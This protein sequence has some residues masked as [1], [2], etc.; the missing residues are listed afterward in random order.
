MTK[1][2]PSEKGRT[3]H[4]PHDPKKFYLGTVKCD[5]PPS[6]MGTIGWDPNVTPTTGYD[7]WRAIMEH[8]D[9]GKMT[10][11]RLDPANI[12]EVVTFTC[13]HCK[14]PVSLRVGNVEMAMEGVFDC[15]GDE[16]TAGDQ[17]FYGIIAILQALTPQLTKDIEDLLDT[18]S[19]VKGARFHCRD[20]F[21][22]DKRNKTP[23]AA[24]TDQQMWDIALEVAALLKKA[25]AKLCLGV[26]SKGTYPSTV[27]GA[28][29]RAMLPE[30]LYPGAFAAAVIS[31]E[32]MHILEPGKKQKVTIDQQ[33]S[34][35]D[36]W[37]IGNTQVQRLLNLT[38]KVETIVATHPKPILLDAVDIL[39]YA[40]GRSL[41]AVV[42]PQA[43]E[44]KNMIET[45]RADATWNPN[46][47]DRPF[48]MDV[49]DGIPVLY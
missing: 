30:H 44:I 32:R 49:K 39:L 16:S 3:K 33:K 41:K 6:P 37:G 21:H 23:W 19:G 13:H 12:P 31:M 15:F 5:Q 28:P 38:G 14:V 17:V 24:H 9:C 36:Y 10:A 27:P 11:F 46:D 42:P 2:I 7:P 43:A 48:Q 47:K 25:G 20:V 1:R 22:S 26:S 18:R 40:H 29:D 35:I 34:K 8:P 45:M 4:S